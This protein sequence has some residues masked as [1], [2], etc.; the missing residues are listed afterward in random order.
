MEDLDKLLLKGLLVLVTA[1]AWYPFLKAV[2][3]ELNEA[4]ADEGGLL[5]R[6]PTAHEL[7][8]LERESVGKPDALIHE[9]WPTEKDRM[10]GRR[11]MRGPA[12]GKRS[13]GGGSGRPGASVRRG[14]F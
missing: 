12:E 8:E 10:A 1:P 2:W 6:L 9:P 5:G 13:T 7:Q 11:Q 3:E 4:M 14:G